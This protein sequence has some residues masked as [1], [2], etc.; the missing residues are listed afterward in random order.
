MENNKK[1]YDN[2]FLAWFN[3]IYSFVSFLLLTAFLPDWW[4]ICQWQFEQGIILFFRLK[5]P[6]FQTTDDVFLT[7]FREVSSIVLAWSVVFLC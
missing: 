2:S 7:V 4:C 1:I 5:S 6:L 3:K